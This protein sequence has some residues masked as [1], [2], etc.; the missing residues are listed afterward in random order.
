MKTE[1][2]GLKALHWRITDDDRSHRGDRGAVAEAVRTIDDA[3]AE[4]LL[5]W[6]A[7]ARTVVHVV[8]TVAP[9]SPPTE[10]SRG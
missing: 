7:G 3:L 10:A 8:V 4:T 5:A 6:P 1:V 2:P 9:A